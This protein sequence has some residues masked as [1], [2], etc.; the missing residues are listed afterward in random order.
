MGCYRTLYC[1][2]GIVIVTIENDSSINKITQIFITKL[3]YIFFESVIKLIS[4]CY[5]FQDFV[6]AYKQALKAICP[7]LKGL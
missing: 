7:L 1:M 5:T 3:V 4:I 2:I 6:I